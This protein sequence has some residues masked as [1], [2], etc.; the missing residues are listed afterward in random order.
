[1]PRAVVQ[2]LLKYLYTDALDYSSLNSQQLRRLLIL[3]DQWL[4]PHVL[5]H[6]HNYILS[7]LCASNALEW[8]LWADE[9]QQAGFADLLFEEAFAIVVKRY[10]TLLRTD[11]DGAMLFARPEVALAITKRAVL[12]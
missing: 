12:G 6:T 5:A 10:K 2:F 9:Q 8:L 11:E 1:M 7:T 3:A 4:L